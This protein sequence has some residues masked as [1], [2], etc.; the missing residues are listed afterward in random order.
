[1]GPG[2]FDLFGEAVPARGH[3][4][5][6]PPVV[7]A[8]RAGP[9]PDAPPPP[10]PV[11]KRLVE[12]AVDAPVYGTFTYSADEFGEELAPGV[13]VQV[14]FG[15]RPLPGFVLGEKDP[16]TLA[17][18]GID[19]HRVRAILKVFPGGSALTLAL[20]ELARWQARHYVCPLGQVL[21]ALLPA[22]VKRQMQ[23]AR[24][25]FI[26]PL[27]SSDEL[28]QAAQALEEKKPRHAA[29]LYLIALHFSQSPEGGSNGHLP[30]SAVQAL[31]D[32]GAPESALK[33]L[34][35]AGVIRILVDLRERRAADATRSQPPTLK[36]EQQRAVAAILNA[37]RANAFRG[38]LL[39]GVTGSGKTEVYLHVLEEVL[40]AGRQA[41]VLVPEIALT[42]Q[43]AERFEQRL[44]RERV[45]V[46]H[47]HIT[48][49]DRAEAWR[50][51]RAGKIDVVVGARSALFA[52]LAR[53]GAIVVDEEHDGAFKQESVPRYHARDTALEL[54]R[55]T[56]AVVI[57]G[58]AT[59]SFESLHAARE[60][61]LELLVLSER[62]RGQAMPTVQVVDIEQ[63]GREVKRFVHLSRLLIQ[64][65]DATLARGEQAIL[66]INRRG[67][68]TVITC[69]RCGNTE[70]CA[71]CDIA[72]TSH[73]NSRTLVC[74][75][76]NFTKAIPAQCEA[77]GNPHLQHWGLGTE[78]VE[79]QIK[80]LLPSARV[81]RMDSDTMTR[82]S[83]YI[84]TLG[85]FRAHQT[86]I[87]IGT[88]MIA[89]G[90]DFP[91]VTLVGVVLADTALHMPD[92]R[93]R[94]RTWQLLAQVSGRAGRSSRGGKVVIQ[95]RRPRDNSIRAAATLDTEAFELDELRERKLFNYPPWRK[96]A[97]IILKGPDEAAVTRA[98]GALRA[99]LDLAV[100]KAPKGFLEIL[101]PT[102]APLSKIEDQFRFHILIKAESSELLSTVLGGA[103][104]E[105]LLKMTG[106]ASVID[107]DP[108]SML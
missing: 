93:A 59:P 27:K 66:F 21:A 87:L 60:K 106:A 76:C 107:V 57:L 71:H 35:A 43:T 64:E 33:S 6:P 40:A 61:R 11:F 55:I 69:T 97:R 24:Q 34:E 10:A 94:E 4:P 102:P 67:Y 73:Q 81:A 38:F 16:A 32:S 19:P 3:T 91:L 77:C 12:I 45:A 82:R 39:H 5:R 30:L 79:T 83:A 22:G 96:L 75:Y 54:G 70:T 80:A 7:R 58:S 15:R 46:L 90:L 25:R 104:A 2:E 85:A 86:D 100:S 14:P 63:E 29:L 72:L 74:H 26:E 1:M 92:F 47:S 98:G 68:A 103:V 49:G 9:P 53:L 88:Q 28:L 95:T 23:A 13:R 84:D 65:F 101:G 78:R 105:S 48:D 37:V 42:P 31:A 56:N 18:D 62:A 108:S 8:A 50:A 41:I 89:K 51:V 36:A 17:Q 44:G 99:V 20:L 52:P